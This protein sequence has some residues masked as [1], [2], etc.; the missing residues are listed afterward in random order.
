MY[1]QLKF[2]PIN[3]KVN[4]SRY[5]QPFE[6]SLIGPKCNQKIHDRGVS[7]SIMA[8]GSPNRLLQ[9]IIEPVTKYRSSLNP[10]L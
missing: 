5:N 9:L 6:V 2:G 4:H 3:T 8:L 1:L 10:F 7:L